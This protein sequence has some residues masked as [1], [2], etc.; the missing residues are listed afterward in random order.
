MKIAF[1]GAAR[2]V[3]GSKHLITLKSG[4]KILLDCGMFQGM[5][6]ETD[7]MNRNLGFVASEVDVM[8]L[9]HAH[10]DHTGLI[11]KLVKEGFKGKIFCTPA[12]KELAGI[13][14]E[15]SAVIQRSDTKFINK[16]RVKQGLPEYD[17]IYS[18]DDVTIA[19]QAFETV[20]YNH[21]KTVLPGI[22]VLFTDAGHIIGSSAVNLKITENNE[23][24]RICFSGDVGRY[25]DVIL[26]SPEV[27]PQADYLILESTYGNKLH[28]E[29][30]NTPDNLLK[31]IQHTCIVKKGKLIIPAFSVGRTQEIL[32]DLNQLSLEKRLPKIPIYVDSPLSREATQ[33]IKNYPQYFNSRIRKVMENDDDPFDFEGLNYIKTVDE[34]KN[35]NF[36]E[37]PC[38]IISA[39]GMADAGRVKH[40]IMNNIGGAQNTILMVG[41]CEPRSLGGKLANGDKQV[42][43]FGEEFDVVAEVGSLK[44]MSAHAD[45]DD[46]CQFISCQ[47]STQIKILFLVHGEYNV[48]QDFAKRLERKGFKDIIGE[49]YGAS[50][51]LGEGAMREAQQ[52]AMLDERAGSRAGKNNMFRNLLGLGVVGAHMFGGKSGSGGA[53]S[54][55]N[56]DWVDPDTGFNWGGMTEDVVKAIPWLMAFM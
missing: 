19:M 55:S 10:I 54:T 7:A 34:S 40:H 37:Q 6:K 28:D 48:Q 44:S 56:A 29:V 23:V 11:P 24:T 50:T 38:V 17:P 42:R 33:M 27:F 31:W 18:L 9:S 39:S 22:E 46:L 12:T 36:L 25:R 30:L 45:Y 14:L 8:F 16:R 4:I 2:T 1:H 26:R 49:E 21:W 47:D 53:G 41:Y 52:K 20:D 43:I 32:Y 13:L 35:L 15:D 51:K 3:T 5:G